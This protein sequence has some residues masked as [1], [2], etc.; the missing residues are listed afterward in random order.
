MIYYNGAQESW[1]EMI[2]YWN[3][4]IMMGKRYK[5]SLQKREEMKKRGVQKDGD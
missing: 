2:I 4:R 1:Q 3:K 5:K